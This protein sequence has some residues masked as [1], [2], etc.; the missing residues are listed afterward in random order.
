M[1][2]RD[3]TIL[4]SRMQKRLKSYTVFT[5]AK[6]ILDSLEAVKTEQEKRKVHLTTHPFRIRNVN[7]RS[8]G[9]LYGGRFS[10]DYDGTLVPFLRIPELA[11]PGADTLDQLKSLA[12]NPKNT[13]VLISGRDKDFL[14]EWFGT[15][16]YSP[17]RRAWGISKSTGRRVAVR[18]RSGPGMELALLQILQRF[19]DRCNG[20]FIEEKFSSLS[21]HYRN[22]PTE[23]G[24]IKAKEL[25]EELRTMVAA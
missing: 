8:S 16:P 15:T 4:I 10:S 6:D 1:P 14:Q 3:R 13:V 19:V 20:S 24:Q 12:G 7:W 17:Y 21:W 5:W 11:I 9:T 25:K 18:N 23:I 22:S 2:L